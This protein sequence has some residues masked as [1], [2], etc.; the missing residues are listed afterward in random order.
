MCRRY[1][2]HKTIAF[3]LQIH[4]I[5]DIFLAT[6]IV[7][8]LNYPMYMLE[9]QI[10]REFFAQHSVLFH[11]FDDFS[12]YHSYHNYRRRLI[13]MLYYFS[14]YRPKCAVFWIA[15]NIGVYAQNS[16]DRR[17]PTRFKG[18]GWYLALKN[19]PKILC[20]LC[21]LLFGQSFL[22]WWP[23]GLLGISTVSIDYMLLLL[24]RII[25]LTAGYS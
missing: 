14:I 15:V 7:F 19:A 8:N 3:P 13:S 25:W 12:I 16:E 1:F 11:W 20:T 9:W 18:G 5:I 21:K 6:G 2:L 4:W 17:G 24:C 22:K 23:G 10:S